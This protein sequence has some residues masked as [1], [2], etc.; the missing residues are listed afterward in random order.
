MADETEPDD[1]AL[2]AGDFHTIAQK[3]IMNAVFATLSEAKMPWTLV[4]P[5]LEA[6]R[7]VCA[8]DFAE[9][10]RITL[11]TMRAEGET[12]VEAEEAFLGIAVADRETGEDWLAETYWLSDV[13]TAGANREDVQ[14]VIA[15]L[16]RTIAKLNLWLEN[17]GPAAAEP[18]E[19]DAEA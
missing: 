2:T 15:G 16:E 5:F 13:A 17:G 8:G 7:E 18:P 10:G 1:S 3:Q 9:N 14:A 12:W 19:T 6:A 4:A 11:H